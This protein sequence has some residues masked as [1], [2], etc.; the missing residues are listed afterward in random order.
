MKH[1]R[2]F[3]SGVALS[4][5]VFIA[6]GIVS[7]ARAFDYELTGC[8]SGKV[9]DENVYLT[10]DSNAQCHFNRG[11]DNCEVTYPVNASDDSSHN[12]KL[13]WTKD[14]QSKVT[15]LGNIRGDDLDGDGFSFS[16]T[17]NCPLPSSAT[18]KAK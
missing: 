12:I 18:M 1:G 5:C 10:F 4:A 16:K 9:N 2:R 11:Q 15:L 7:E 3:C 13:I 6:A 17:T 14:D 8:W